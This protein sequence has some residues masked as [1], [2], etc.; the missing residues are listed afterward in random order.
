[1]KTLWIGTGAAVMVAGAI[2]FAFSQTSGRDATTTESTVRAAHTAPAVDAELAMPDAVPEAAPERPQALPS[3]DTVYTIDADGFVWKP[4]SYH[5]PQVKYNGDGTF[6]GRK[7][8]RIVEADGSMRE[9]PVQYTATPMQKRIAL[10]RRQPPAHVAA[11]A[12]IEVQGPPE[13]PAEEPQATQ[14]D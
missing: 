13:A 10:K 4:L 2:A 6:T 7:L 3:N 1:M 11:L 8:F 12:G 14:D 5:E 9:I